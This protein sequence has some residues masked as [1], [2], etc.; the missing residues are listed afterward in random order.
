MREVN[1]R[2][3]CIG[4]LKLQVIL[5]K[6]ATNYRALLRKMT[7]EDKA[8]YD[9]TAPCSRHPRL[10]CIK[11]WPHLPPSSPM[12]VYVCMCVCMCMCVCVYVCERESDT[13]A[14]S[15]HVSWARSAHIVTHGRA[16]RAPSHIF[17]YI[18]IYICICI[19]IY[20]YVYDIYRV[21]HGRAARAH[22]L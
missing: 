3:R 2:M 11:T 14:R 7:L 17:I 16:A 5:R 8:S 19:Y 22:L 13:W 18:Y 12:C 4:C 6:R 15:A 1:E 9:S 10:G 20:I 21:T